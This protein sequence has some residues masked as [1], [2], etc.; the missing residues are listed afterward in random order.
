MITL[1]KIVL[2]AILFFYTL[3][4][5]QKIETKIRTEK[6]KIDAEINTMLSD[7]FFTHDGGGKP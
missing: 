4:N 6:I 7:K 2:S 5:Q 1:S 3:Q